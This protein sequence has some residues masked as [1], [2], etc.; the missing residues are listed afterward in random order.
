MRA[1]WL[2]SSFYTGHR[3]IEQS[4]WGSQAFLAKKQPQIAQRFSLRYRH[5]SHSL[6]RSW[7]DRS[8]SSLKPD[9]ANLVMAPAKETAMQRTVGAE[10]PPPGG[11]ARSLD[12]SRLLSGTVISKTSGRRNMFDLIRTVVG[13]RRFRDNGLEILGRTHGDCHDCFPAPNGSSHR[14]S[15]NIND[16]PFS[17]PSPHDLEC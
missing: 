5:R 4:S 16:V 12:G 13:S 9:A 15:V 3:P 2:P 1:I 7:C 14:P 11:A 6:T 8:S 17:G 10:T